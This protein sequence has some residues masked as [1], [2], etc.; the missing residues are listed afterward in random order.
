MVRILPL[1][2]IHEKKD[3]LF[4]AFTYQMLFQGKESVQGPNKKLW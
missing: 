2:I 1:A 3:T 4:G